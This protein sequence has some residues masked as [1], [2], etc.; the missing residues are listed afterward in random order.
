MEIF[1]EIIIQTFP[2]SLSNVPIISYTQREFFPEIIDVMN[3]TGKPSD[4]CFEV[5]G[6]TEIFRRWPI[7]GPEALIRGD[8]PGSRDHPACK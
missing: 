8:Q 3:S 4:F 5:H 6:F 2:L 7:P 1:P